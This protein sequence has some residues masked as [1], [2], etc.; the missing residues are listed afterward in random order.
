MQENKE[1]K[2]EPTS[3]NRPLPPVVYIWIYNKAKKV[4]T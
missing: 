1:Y 3:H 4:Q 2:K